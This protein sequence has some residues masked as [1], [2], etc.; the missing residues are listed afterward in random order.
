MWFAADRV[1][2]KLDAAG[3]E[4]LRHTPFARADGN[5]VALAADPVDLS[6]W[7]ATVTKLKHIDVG[8]TTLLTRSFPL[9]RIRDLVL[10]RDTIPPELSFTSP[11]NGAVLNTATPTIRLS[12]SDVGTG[13][14]TSTL[15]FTANGTVLLI[16][17]LPPRAPPVRQ[18]R[19]WRA[20]RPPSARPSKTLRAISPIQRV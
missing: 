4:I 5:I 17:R 1:L 7:A 13:V 10:Y 20:G 12:Y 8:G 11:A 15:V 18:L 2:G 14:D 6:V 9:P 19:P 16:V 3:N